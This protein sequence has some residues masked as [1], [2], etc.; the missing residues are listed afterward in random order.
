MVNP[1][2]APAFE[3]PQPRAQYQQ[4]SPL[5]AP[6]GPVDRSV[7]ALDA[8][9]FVFAD[10]NW[11]KNAL[12]GFLLQ[13]IPLAGPVALNGWLAETHRRLVWHFERPVPKFSFDDFGDYLQRGWVALVAQL[14]VSM[15]LLLPMAFVIGFAVAI[16]QG[17]GRTQE[18][19]LVLVLL[20]P[21]IPLSMLLPFAF[22]SLTTLGELTERLGAALSPAHNFRYLSKIWAP[23]LGAMIVMVVMGTLLIVAGLLACVVGMYI[24]VQVLQLASVHLRWQLYNESLRRGAGH[25]EVK[26]PVQLPSERRV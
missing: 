25:M 15:A 22:L 1:Y 5:G 14:A 18:P 10:P 19:Y 20:L 4:A 13:F 3:P 17:T 12:Y 7:S 23:A 24:S 21:I 11:W 8:L 2:Q 6:P 26:A 16:L 9:R